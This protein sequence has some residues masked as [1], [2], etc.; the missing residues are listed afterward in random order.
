M[1]YLLT[2]FDRVDNFNGNCCF[3]AVGNFGE[4]VALT[5]LAGGGLI[6]T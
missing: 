2:Y 3:T 5:K 6:A 1:K 4:L